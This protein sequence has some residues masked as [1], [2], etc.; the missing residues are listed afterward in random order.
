[1]NRKQELEI[2][3]PKIRNSIARNGAMIPKASTHD[4]DF[5][6]QELKSDIE[7]LEKYIAELKIIIT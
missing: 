3:I 2:I 5:C 6:L 1:M 7:D 4:S